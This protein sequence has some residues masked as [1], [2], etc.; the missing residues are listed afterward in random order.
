MSK[1]SELEHLPPNQPEGYHRRQGERIERRTIEIGKGKFQ[2]FVTKST[3]IECELR[4]LCGASHV[5]LFESTF[6]ACTFKPRREM[7]NL[8][9]NGMNFSHCVFLGKYTG[10]R[11]GN[12]EERDVSDVRDCDFS[13][14]NLFH[15]CDFLEGV[16]VG[17]LKWPAWPHVVVADLPRSRKDWLRLELPEELRVIQAVIGREEP[18]AHAVTLFLPAETQHPE[19]LRELLKSQS[20]IIGP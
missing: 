19:A 12:L 7:K 10:C 18:K 8:R 4:I 3:L 16:D 2:D 14:A 5:N 1:P 20:Y 17:S 15:L 9:L 6:E 13:Q 11:F